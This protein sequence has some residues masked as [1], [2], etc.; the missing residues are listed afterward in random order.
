MKT[1]LDL[2]DALLIRA[3]QVAA[4][5]RR[6]LRELVEQG[7][8]KELQG[9][10]RPRPARTIRWVTVRGGLPKDADLADRGRMLERFGRGL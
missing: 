5:Q 10:D 7:L 1:T 4:G 3:K 2:D 9:T 6:P 8:R